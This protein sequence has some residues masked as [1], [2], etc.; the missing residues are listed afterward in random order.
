MDLDYF[1]EYES[2]SSVPWKHGVLEPK[3]KQLIAVALNASVTHM[4]REEIRAHIRQALRFGASKE[5][6]METF[7][8][9]GIIGVHGHLTIGLPIFAEEDQKGRRRRHRRSLAGGDA[10]DKYADAGRPLSDSRTSSARAG[11]TSTRSGTT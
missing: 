7:Q 5:E 4:Y 11:G 1:E 9:V 2:F 6:I 8:L 10:V 3:V